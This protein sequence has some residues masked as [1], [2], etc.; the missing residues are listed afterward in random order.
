MT[1][2]EYTAIM[3]KTRR[4][5]PLNATEQAL[6]YE[7]VALCNEDDWAETFHVASA[8]L[9]HTLQIS[10]NTLKTARERLIQVGLI[11]YKS[12]K[13]KRQ[14]S[15]YSLST[16]SKFDTV[17]RGDDGGDGKGDNRG[18]DEKKLRTNI[19][20]IT[21]QKHL[22]KIEKESFDFE[23]GL[24]GLGIPKQL[25][26]EWMLIRKKKKAINTETAFKM[27]V[28]EVD[29]SKLS[30]QQ[31]IEKAISRS[32]VSFEAS[33]VEEKLTPQ[34]FKMPKTLLF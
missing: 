27:F 22:K 10:E 24:L 14:Y 21:K 17:G 11:S 32:W 13:S 28:R 23:N 19:N 15:K 29:K 18:D 9:C 26:E 33:W 2:Y 8:E 6:F 30:Y 4:R 7:L 25:V 12:G 1:G 3:R 34:A 5:Q 16:T 31:A 20:Y